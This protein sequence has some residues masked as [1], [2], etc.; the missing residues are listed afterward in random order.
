M[1]VQ[2][3][4]RSFSLNSEATGLHSNLFG[5]IPKLAGQAL[6]RQPLTWNPC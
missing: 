1:T 3:V 6:S 4:W 2:H 5:V